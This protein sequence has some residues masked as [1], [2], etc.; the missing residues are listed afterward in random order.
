MGGM[1]S[2]GSE[3]P[4]PNQFDN[5]M[6]TVARDELVAQIEDRGGNLTV[7]FH[8]MAGGAE[9]ELAWESLSLVENKV[10]PA[11]REKGIQTGGSK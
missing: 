2:K 9:P 7:M 6:M 5:P 1:C 8:P 11:L 3:D 4:E 10:I